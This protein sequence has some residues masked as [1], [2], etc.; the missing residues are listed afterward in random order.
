MADEFTSDPTEKKA[1][2]IH[3][4]IDKGCQTCAAVLDLK[5]N[6]TLSTKGQNAHVSMKKVNGTFVVTITDIK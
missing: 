1:G 5:S 2:A 6:F 4:N 3:W